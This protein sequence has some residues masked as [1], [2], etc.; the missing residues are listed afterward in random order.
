M[1]LTLPA[2]KRPKPVEVLDLARQGSL[3]ASPAP[4]LRI[5]EVARRTGL[6]LRSIP[7]PHSSGVEGSRHSHMRELRIP[8]GA[9]MKPGRG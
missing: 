2:G 1:G 9:P 7:F 8:S 3:S 4:S 6:P 5:G